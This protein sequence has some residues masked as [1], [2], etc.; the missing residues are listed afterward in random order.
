MCS[1]AQ[2][3][4]CAL[5]CIVGRSLEV[6]CA[7]VACVHDDR[8]LFHVRKNNQVL[9]PEIEPKLYRTLP[10]SFEVVAK[11]PLQFVDRMMVP[12]QVGF[13]EKL[14]GVEVQTSRRT[15]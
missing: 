6:P 2:T 4:G 12:S 15:R 11:P 5:Q 3:G 9:M 1:R 10:H 7:D 8:S 13:Q 14:D